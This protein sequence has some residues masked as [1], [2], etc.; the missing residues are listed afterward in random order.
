MDTPAREGKTK[1]ICEESDVKLPDP[2][3]TYMSFCTNHHDSPRILHLSCHPTPCQR[4]DDLSRRLRQ[5]DEDSLQ[6]RKPVRL[7]DEVEKVAQSTIGNTVGRH[8]EE[9]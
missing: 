1:S 2:T 5:T 8:Q 9:D 7:Q 4:D 3:G 6:G